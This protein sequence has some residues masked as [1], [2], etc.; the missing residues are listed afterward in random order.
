[1]A[2]RKIKS[3]TPAKRDETLKPITFE[4]LGEEF[5]AYPKVAGIAVLEFIASSEDNN[6]STAK[7]ILDYL[8]NAMSDEQ[9][10]RFYKLVSAPEHEVEISTLSEIVGYLIEEQTARPT[11]AS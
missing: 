10:T 8:K 5:E 6:S 1:M 2:V 3:F 11:S 7:G 9:Y 4:L